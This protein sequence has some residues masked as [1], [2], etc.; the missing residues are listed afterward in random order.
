MLN[1]ILQGYDPKQI[2]KQ[3]YMYSLS[4]TS[5]STVNS[6]LNAHYLLFYVT[7]KFQR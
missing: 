7:G 2:F 5:H 6:Y 4:N 1:F 3:V